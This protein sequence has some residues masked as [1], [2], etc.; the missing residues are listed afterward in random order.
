MDVESEFHRDFAGEAETNRQY[1]DS[2]ADGGRTEAA[3][4]ALRKA[5]TA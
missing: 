5:K 1:G 3:V 2:K 4:G